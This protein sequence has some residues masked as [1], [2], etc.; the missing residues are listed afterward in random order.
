MERGKLM[1]QRKHLITW[2]KEVDA[3]LEGVA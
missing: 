1:R 2:L 3:K